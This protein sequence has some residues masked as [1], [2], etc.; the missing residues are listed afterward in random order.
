M[1]FAVSLILIQYVVVGDIAVV[2]KV[3]C[4]RLI[5][6]SILIIKPGSWLLIVVARNFNVVGN[7]GIWFLV[8]WVIVAVLKGKHRLLR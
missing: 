1:S 2:V 3:G 5:G 7:I 4:H 6:Q 8:T